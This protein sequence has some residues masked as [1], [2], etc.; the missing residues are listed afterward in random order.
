MFYF[1]NALLR[2][3][4]T[5]SK[6]LNSKVYGRVEKSSFGYGTQTSGRV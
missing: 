2:N 5:N 4:E 6:Y 3:K 1:F